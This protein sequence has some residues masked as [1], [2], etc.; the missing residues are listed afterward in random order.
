MR[1]HR[2]AE[3]LKII[4]GKNSQPHGGSGWELLGAD[5]SF[6][7]EE[8]LKAPTYCGLGLGD[9]LL[10]ALDSVVFLVLW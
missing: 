1:S 2:G 10:S 4:L 7:F 5:Y 8:Y 3:R 9:G 6:V